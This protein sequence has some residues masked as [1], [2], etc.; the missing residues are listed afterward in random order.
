MLYVMWASSPFVAYV[1]IKVP[2]FARRSKEQ[3]LRWAQNIAP[4]T[5]LDLTTIKSYGFP[6]VSRMFVA[7]LRPVKARLGIENL[8]RLPRAPPSKPKPWWVSN[9]QRRFFVGNERKKSIETSIWQIVFSQ[10]Q[11]RKNLAVKSTST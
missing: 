4:E 8:S 6:R 11:A 10:I 1:H 2:L 5:E 7:D 3:L 9:E